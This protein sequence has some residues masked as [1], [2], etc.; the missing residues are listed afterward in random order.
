MPRICY[1]RYD[2][3][4]GLG[5]SGRPEAGESIRA[6][7]EKPEPEHDR[8]FPLCFS[9]SEGAALPRLFSPRTVLGRQ[10][11][12][13]RHLVLARFHWPGSP[14][15]ASCRMVCVGRRY[16]IDHSRVC[17]IPHPKRNPEGALEPAT[18]TGSLRAN[19]PKTLKDCTLLLSRHHS[20]YGSGS[21]SRP[22]P[23]PPNPAPQ[24][25]MLIYNIHY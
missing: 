11:N 15:R 2:M 6:W 18:G 24:T 1:M 23:P 3:F 8:C 10:Q 21:H 19:P 13:C 12:P 14:H 25:R 5:G 17:A 16:A 9:F 22:A 20:R 4:A 7:A